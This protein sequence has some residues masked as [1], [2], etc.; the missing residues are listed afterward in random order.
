MIEN[1]DWAS[2]YSEEFAA[3]EGLSTDGLTAEGLHAAATAVASAGQHLYDQWHA[4]IEAGN[5]D[6]YHLYNSQHEF[7]QHCAQ[8]RAALH[9]Q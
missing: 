2:P 7:I 8:A 9:H 5:Y 4:A 1:N 6:S 3:W